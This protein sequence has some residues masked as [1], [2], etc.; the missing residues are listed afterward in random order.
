MLNIPK[1]L[2]LAAHEWSSYCWCL[3][4]DIPS[5]NKA[6]ILHRADIK[7]LASYW[8]TTYDWRATEAQLN[9][10]PHFKTEI[11]VD[12]FGGLDIH[13]LHQKSEVKGAIPLL[14]VHGWPG[15]W[16][17]VTKMLPL[18]KGGHGKPAFHVVAP[19]LPNYWSRKA[20]RLSTTLR[21]ATSLCLPWDMTNTVHSLSQRLEVSF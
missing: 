6:L 12:G 3:S 20:L 2:G 1:R 10:L 18:L 8:A 11:L 9:R 5:I 17:E 19:S 13:F 14:F 21:H 15:S 7:R 4:N 16:I